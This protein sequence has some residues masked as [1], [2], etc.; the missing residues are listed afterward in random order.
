MVTERDFYKPCGGHP[1]LDFTNSTGRSPGITRNERLV[2]Y[3]AL[4]RWCLAAGVL[5]ED[6]AAGLRRLGEEHPRAAAA[7]HRRAIALRED[8]FA[9]WHALV[10]DRPLPESSLATLNRELANALARA[11]VEPR[12]DGPAWGWAAD[13][14]ALDAPLWPLAR[15]AAELL[16]SDERERVSECD[17]STCLWLFVDRSRNRRRRWC[18]MQGCGNRE[19]VRKHRRRQRRGEPRRGDD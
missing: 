19:K 13:D 9:I 4:V 7:V 18:E 15:A 14:E 11:R 16:V 8:L 3:D 6:R 1:S 12:P 10:H 2:D 17:A 5:G